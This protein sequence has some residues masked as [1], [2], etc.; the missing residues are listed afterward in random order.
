MISDVPFQLIIERTETDKQPEYLSCTKL[1]RFVPGRRRVYEALW[2]DKIVI[3]K[4]FS[5]TLSAK[6]H[7]RREWRGLTNLEHRKL[8]APE[9]L[10][11]GKTEDGQ[12]VVVA[13]KI[14]GSST[15]LEIFQKLHKSTEKL[16]LLTLVGKELAKQHIEGVMQK[17]L[18]LG[19]FLMQGNEVFLLDAG[20]IWFYR[21]EL[22][23]KNSVAQ[24]AMLAAWLPDNRA[25]EM[26]ELC[27]QY[28]E[29][30]GWD[31]E[32]SDQNI[33][34]KY[35]A[36]C[37][38]RAVRKGL[39]KSLRTSKRFIKVGDGR[40]IGVFD[41]SF[42]RDAKPFDFI[43]RIDALMDNGK[44]L[45]NGNTCY[46][47]RLTWNGM[48]IVVKRYNYKGIIHSLRHTIKKSRARRCWLNGHRLGIYN[49]ATPKP[50][51]FFEQRRGFIISKSYLVT[52][53]IEGSSLYYYLR[54]ENISRQK[55]KA[56]VQETK[57]L[58]DEMARYRITHGDL[59]HTNILITEN[60]PVLTDLDSMRFHKCNLTFRTG[61]VKDILRFE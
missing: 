29:V 42:C 27:K 36:A 51:A 18:H 7:L 25:K 53:Y 50:L 20:Q 44:V 47:S 34:W 22:G 23:R 55:R 24:L 2:N 37:R 13:E 33:F 16:E 8:N 9:P 4:V 45:K 5:H 40:Y 35:L 39:R 58:L 1:L 14:S 59:K 15:A 43:E 41:R 38:R 60:G 17:D 28:Y 46:V 52:E 10:F 26:N 57:N 61:R 12:W 21:C 6:R 11:Y 54:D 30:R 3:A 49:I 32:R 56:A 48:D 19:N 31:F